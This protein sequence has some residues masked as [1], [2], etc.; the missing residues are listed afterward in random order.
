MYLEQVPLEELF[1]QS[2]L[3][4]KHAGVVGRDAEAEQLKP[5]KER[6]EKGGR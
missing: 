2:L 3:E 1:D 5:E 6:G 4:G